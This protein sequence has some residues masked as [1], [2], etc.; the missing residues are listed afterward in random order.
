[1][2]TEDYATEAQ[3]KRLYAVLHS[4]GY[5]PKQWKKDHDITSYSKL[6]RGE[7]SD[8]I[9]ELEFE[10]VEKKVRHDNATKKLPEDLKNGLQ[11]QIFPAEDETE[12]PKDEIATMA[13]VMQRCIQEANRI[14]EEEIDGGGL[15]EASKAGIMQRL[16]TTLF[17]EA[18]RRGH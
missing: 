2:A 16:A 7:C 8:Y 4:L 10:E 6:T 14:V 5:D 17:I 1:M 18:M 9:D 13:A 12:T 11:K 3:I 15:S